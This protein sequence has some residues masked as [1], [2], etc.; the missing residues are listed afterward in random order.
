MGIHMLKRTLFYF[1]AFILVVLSFF[2]LY[3][4]FITSIKPINEMFSMPPKFIT[5]NPLIDHYVEVFRAQPF[6]LYYGNSL[7]VAAY[8]LVICLV[9]GSMLGYAVSRL[10][11]KGKSIVLL[12]VV[13]TSMFPPM[14]MVL[15]IFM[16]LREFDLL[17]SYTGL[18]LVHAA[19][20]LPMIIWLLSAL[21]KEIP[22]ELEEAAFI[23]GYNRLQTFFRIMLPLA[24]PALATAG[25][26]VFVHS[27]NEFLFAFTMMS[28]TTKRTLPVGIMMYP[29][30]HSFPWATISAA[31]V[32]SVV[33]LVLLILFFQKRIVQ[34]LTNGAVKG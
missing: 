24:A 15:P 27:W 13:S 3:W 21:F 33:P 26:L 16:G 30:E 18:S 1:T 34:G 22:K 9:F 23:D 7:L 12:V 4:L 20:G 8:T 31:V 19:F 14:T 11:F 29:G 28:E 10:Q 17:N 25:I 5:L 2:P 32:M 6:E